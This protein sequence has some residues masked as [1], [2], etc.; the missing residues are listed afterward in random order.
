MSAA[1]TGHGG[2]AGRLLAHGVGSRQDLPIPF[3]YALIG[4]AVALVVSFAALG[5]LSRTRRLRPDTDG[6]P[7]PADLARGLDSPRLRA[8]GLVLGVVMLSRSRPSSAG[9]SWVS[10]SRMTGRSV[11]C[12]AGARWPGRSR[13]LY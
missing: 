7:L 9:T 8:L 3:S 4:A 11:F 6:R 10:C 5:L 2:A 12:R 1:G 13:C